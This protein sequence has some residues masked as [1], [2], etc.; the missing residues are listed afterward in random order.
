[1]RRQGDSEVYPG[2]IDTHL[3]CRSKQ[4]CIRRGARTADLVGDYQVPCLSD[5]ESAPAKPMLNTVRAFRCSSHAS[6]FRSTFTM[7]S[8][9]SRSATAGWD[10][11][12]SSAS[13]RLRAA[14]TRIGAS[15]GLDVAMLSEPFDGAFQ[16]GL[17]RG[18]GQPQLTNSFRC[19]EPHLVPRKLYAFERDVRLPAS[20]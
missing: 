11:R 19:V 14:T 6:I 13:S 3:H 7:P 15:V 9:V 5:D 4:L 17:D 8:P 10:S 12:A 1:M 18:L 16:R 2:P 20:D